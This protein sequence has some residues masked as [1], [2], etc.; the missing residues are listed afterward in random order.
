MKKLVAD[1]ASLSF[2]VFYSIIT[3]SRSRVLR[4][5]RLCKVP[6]AG[7][8]SGLVLDKIVAVAVPTH[9]DKTY[10][11]PFNPDKSATAPLHLDQI[12]TGPL[13]IHKT[14]SSSIVSG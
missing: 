9:L 5:A 11:G 10:I 6:G 2:A 4:R 14:C 1:V 12:N 8:R 13:Y 7:A 3:G